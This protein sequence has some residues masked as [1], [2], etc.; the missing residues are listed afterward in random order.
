MG[1]RGQESGMEALNQTGVNKRKKGIASKKKRIKE[2]EGYIK[3][4]Y[5]KYPEWDTFDIDR[6]QREIGHWKQEIDNLE[7]EIREYEKEIKDYEE[8]NNTKGNS[9]SAYS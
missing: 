2:H 6:K 7:R 8:G 1:G 4:P 9:T 5:Q 3:N